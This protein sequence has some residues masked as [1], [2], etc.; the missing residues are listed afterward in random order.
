MGGFLSVTVAMLSIK[1]RNSANLVQWKDLSTRAVGKQICPGNT[2]SS[3]ST[4]TFNVCFGM[5]I[6]VLDWSVGQ[7][8]WASAN[9]GRG[10]QMEP[11]DSRTLI[12]LPR[13]SSYS[14]TPPSVSIP[15]GPPYPQS[16]RLSQQCSYTHNGRDAYRVRM[17]SQPSGPPTSTPAPSPVGHLAQ[18]EVTVRSVCIEYSSACCSKIK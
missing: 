6:I 9:I 14:A 3:Y 12:L 2:S 8:E 1:T 13:C 7:Q 17:C 5:G 15:F 16:V 4:F 11:Q 18:V 10:W